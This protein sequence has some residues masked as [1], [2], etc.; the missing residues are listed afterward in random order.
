MI[1]YRFRLI[2]VRNQIKKMVDDDNIIL[3]VIEKFKL[4]KGYREIRYEKAE[5]K[6]ISL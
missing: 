3:S 2:Y 6:G 4:I 5:S 1:N